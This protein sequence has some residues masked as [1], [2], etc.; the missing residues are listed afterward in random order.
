MPVGIRLASGTMRAVNRQ[1]DLEFPA[2]PIKALCERY[3][4]REL[5]IF[6]S[7]LEGGAREDS[8]LDL[9]V[10][11]EPTAEVGFVALARMQRSSPHC[12]T[13]K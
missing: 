1:T 5:S 11:F 13:G 6:G 12:F 7:T 8:D 3:H 4:A 2:E 9:L 10:E